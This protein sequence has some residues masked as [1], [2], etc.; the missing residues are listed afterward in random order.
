MP[1]PTVKFV[2][3]GIEK[4][5]ETKLISSKVSFYQSKRTTDFNEI[6]KLAEEFS[7]KQNFVYSLSKLDYNL[8]LSDPD[9]G[10]FT[11]LQ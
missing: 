4:L 9:M 2:L 8:K 1:S 6:I 7:N 11:F 3:D 5:K 10:I